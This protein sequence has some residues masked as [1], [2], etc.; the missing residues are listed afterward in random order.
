MGSSEDDSSS[1]SDGSRSRSRSSSSSSSD[2]KKK[3]H[4]R[5][6]HAHSRDKKKKKRNEKER[7]HKKKK[8][9]HK[10]HKHDKHDKSAKQREP[11]ERSIITGKRLKR[12]ARDDAEGDARRMA[13]LAQMNEG[14]DEEAAQTFAASSSSSAPAGSVGN[15]AAALAQKALAD[16]AYMLEL[17]RKSNEMQA[18]KRQRL[19]ALMGTAAPGPGGASYGGCTG[20]TPLD[21]A[22]RMPRNYKEERAAREREE[23]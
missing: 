6:K 9:E 4:K 18:V 20:V 22:P 15:A 11:V 12:E 19:G 8:K 21:E 23:L 13:I 16:P 17:M 7:R 5:S 1:S 14:E 2:K 3:H 10:R